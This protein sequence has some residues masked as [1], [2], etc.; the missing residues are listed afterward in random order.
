MPHTH[1]AGSACPAAQPPP[2]HTALSWVGPPSGQ[3][4]GRVTVKGRV[5][6][7][8][9]LSSCSERALRG[10]E[11]GSLRRMGVGAPSKRVG[12][13]GRRAC[14]VRAT[15]RAR[16]AGQ[17]AGE[18]GP[19]SPGRSLGSWWG[20]RRLGGQAWDLGPPPLPIRPAP[21]LAPQYP[22]DGRATSPPVP[23]QGPVRGQTGQA[24]RP[25]QHR[26]GRADHSPAGDVGSEPGPEQVG[27]VAPPQAAEGRGAT[28][29]H[30][31]DCPRP[32]RPPDSAQAWTVWCW[33]GP[34]R[35][36]VLGSGHNRETG[37][38]GP[39]ASPHTV[40]GLLLWQS[41]W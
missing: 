17:G 31:Q 26:W 11:G 12:R 32:A 38:A 24:G 36:G 3:P 18:R 28:R 21:S 19:R 16:V 22:E 35:A 8:R 9:L 1:R 2:G 13:R 33:D 10:R 30:S 7:G 39:L 6:E 23:V 34:G 14:P 4:Q 15:V 27:K 25:V 5:G 20:W 37:P 29:S 40:P 41:A